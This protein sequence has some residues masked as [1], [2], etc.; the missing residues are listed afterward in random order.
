M[1]GEPLDLRI[2]GRCRGGRDGADEARGAQGTGRPTNP[3]LFLTRRTETGRPTNLT[4]F[5]TRRTENRRGPKACPPKPGPSP[6][7]G[8]QGRPPSPFSP[9]RT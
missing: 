2:G 1:Y 9:H 3:D 4:L 6:G 5:L 7:T 8:D